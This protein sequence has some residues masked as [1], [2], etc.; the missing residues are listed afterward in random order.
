[1]YLNASIA[2]RLF[3]DERSI[4]EKCRIACTSVTY[5]DSIFQLIVQKRNAKLDDFDRATRDI[6]K[7]SFFVSHGCTVLNA[8]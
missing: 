2:R 8:S 1:M 7:V 6:N 3:E 4:K 5:H